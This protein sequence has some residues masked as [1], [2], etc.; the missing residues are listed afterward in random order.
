[1]E[2]AHH[3]NLDCLNHLIDKGAK[4]EATDS[5]S[6]TPQAAPSPPPS[7][8]AATVHPRVGG[9]RRVSAQ[10]KQTALHYAVAQDHVSCVKSLLKAGADVSLK[11]RTQVSD[12]AD[13]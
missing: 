2:A 10:V 1:M 3:A 6:A 12:G 11:I 8:P 5:V 4:L 13:S 7:P 9:R